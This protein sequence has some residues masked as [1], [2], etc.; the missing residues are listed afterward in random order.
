M[1]KISNQGSGKTLLNTIKGGFAAL[2]SIAAMA[3]S[4]Q[5]AES[6]KDRTIT[7]VVP[8]GSGG[9]YHVYCQLVVQHIAR[10]IPGN[11]TTVIQNR[12]G[13]GGARA[14][15]YMANAAPK[16]GTVIAMVAPGS[17]TLPLSRKNVKFD[18]TKFNWL[19]SLASRAYVFHTWH[20]APAQTLDELKKTQIIA[21]S[22]GTASGAHVIAGL[23]N[24]VLGTKMKIISGYKGGG[25][26]DL[27]MQRGE[28][29]GRGNFFNSIESRNGEWLTGKKVSLIMALGPKIEEGLIS[30]KVPYAHELVKPG[31]VDARAVELIRMNFNVGQAFYLPP[32]TPKAIVDTM[33]KAFADMVAAPEIAAEAKR[34]NFMFNPQSAESVISHIDKAFGAADNETVERY[35]AIM[36]SSYKKKS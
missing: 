25:K 21:G 19:G 29:H 26:L 24:T 6:F 30:R 22:T 7:V 32:G 8:S 9:S 34:R 1:K 14:A 4:A 33:R 20:T 2:F 23:M 10:H 11:P 3:A 12:P 16:D 13:A 36:S 27:A 5:A 28:I 15:A 17:I 18:A 31:T 35:R